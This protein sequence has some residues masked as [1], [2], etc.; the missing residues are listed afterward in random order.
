VRR[1][2]FSV[3]SSCGRPDR[4]RGGGLV[5]VPSWHDRAAPRTPPTERERSAAEFHA[6]EREVGGAFT[7]VRGQASSSQP[8]P[9]ARARWVSGLFLDAGAETV[10]SF[11]A[12]EAQASRSSG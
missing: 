2:R 8:P 4:L 1:G 10:G 11:T 5:G 7:R 9:R 12:I 6:R 3:R